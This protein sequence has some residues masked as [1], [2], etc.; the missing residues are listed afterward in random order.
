MYESIGLLQ[1]KDKA[2]KMIKTNFGEKESIECLCES[3]LLSRGTF[4]NYFK[5]KDNLSYSQ[6][7][8]QVLEF[9]IQNISYDLLKVWFKCLIEQP[10]IYE[11]PGLNYVYTKEEISYAIHLLQK[12]NFIFYIQKMI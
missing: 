1:K 10:N 3:L 5:N 2:L 6:L 12:D 4:F 11:I 9:G 8:Y 7:I